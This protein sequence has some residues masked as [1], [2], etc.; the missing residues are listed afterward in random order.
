[1]PDAETIVIS[2]GGSL[3]VPSQGDG[4][5]DTAFL[6]SLRAFVAQSVAEEKRLVLIAGGGKTARLY[7]S[8]LE[9]FVEINP[10][11]QDW[12]GIHATRLNG[13]LLKIALKGYAEEFLVTNPN[14]LPRSDKPVIVG[15]GYKP[16]A[17][18]DLRAVQIAK[19]IGAKKVVNLSN[20]DYAYTADPNE[21]PSA[22]KIEEMRWDEFLSL[23]PS[24]WSPGLSSPFDPIAS[25][26]AQA[27]GMEVAIINGTKLEEVKKY[28]NDEPFVGSLVR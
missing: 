4:T 28:L 6:E 5:P 8:A 23:I 10:D 3:I 13:Q 2:V 7:Q 1:M 20:I 19:N 24:E 27:A 26:E 9:G 14:E 18:T 25:R 11:D 21:D 12:I 16:G 22:Q 17:S 15:G